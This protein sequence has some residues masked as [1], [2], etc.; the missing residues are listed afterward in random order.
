MSSVTEV[1]FENRGKVGLNQMIKGTV[2]V[3]QSETPCKEGNNTRL[4]TVPLK[5]LTVHR[6]KRDFCLNILK[7]TNPSKMR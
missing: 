1:F 5:S 6:V 7:P 3:V 2:S 4:T